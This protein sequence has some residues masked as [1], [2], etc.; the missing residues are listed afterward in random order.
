LAW[1][2]G[3]SPGIRTPEYFSFFILKRRPKIGFEEFFSIF[4]II[5]FNPAKIITLPIL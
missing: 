1:E 2:W 3:Y 5:K 4:H